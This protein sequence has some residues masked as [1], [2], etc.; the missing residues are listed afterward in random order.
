MG[1]QGDK[2]GNGKLVIGGNFSMYNNTL[3]LEIA[4]IMA[5]SVS[6]NPATQLLL[7]LGD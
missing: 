7:L 3:R 6:F 4:R 2:Q 1:A 5:R